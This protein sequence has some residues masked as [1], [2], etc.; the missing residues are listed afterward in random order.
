MF[1][2]PKYVTIGKK[3]VTEYLESLSGYLCHHGVKGQK[4]G[5]KNGPPYPLDKKKRK[6]KS[7]NYIIEDPETGDVF[8]MVK[9]S[10][11]QNKEIFAGKGSNTPLKSE[12]SEGLSKQI[13]GK[14]SEWSH[15]KGRCNVNY[16]GEERSAEVH[17]FEESSVGKHKFKI[18]KWLDD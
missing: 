11:I 10:K 15:C 1:C 14:P 8:S 2:N 18:K 16:Y 6:K 9:G 3:W 17:W 4:W 12:V 13:G 5:V 7:N